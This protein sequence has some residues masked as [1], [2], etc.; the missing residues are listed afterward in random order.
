MKKFL[1]AFTLL[2]SPIIL[3]CFAQNVSA[4]M[5]VPQ[6]VKTVVLAKDQVINSDY[7][8]TGA[9]VDI[10]GKVNGDA[11]VAGGSVTVSGTINGDL[12]VAGGNINIIGNVTGNARIIGGNIIVT[13]TIGRN[14]STAGGSLNLTGG[15]RVGGSITGAGANLL[16]YGPVTKDVR[17]AGGQVTLG[18]MIG[19]NAFVAARQIYLSS[20][21]NIAGNLTYWSNKQAQMTS[22]ATISG[23]ISQNVLPK[24]S[25][26]P[27]VQPMKFAPM[28]AGFAFFGKLTGFL[29]SFVVGLLLISFFPAYIRK[30]VVSTEKSFW[31]NVGF[32]LIASIAT[33]I[34]IVLLFVTLIGIQLAILTGMFF[35]LVLCVAGIIASLVIGKW[36]IGYVSKKERLIW[37]LFTGLVIYKIVAAIPVVGWLFAII[38]TAAGLGA[39]IMERKIAHTQLKAK[40]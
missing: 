24:S 31:M 12:L 7:V 18:N 16:L 15:A 27:R 30:V 29:A 20:S 23:K 28:L 21:S 40:N 19:G 34:V 8:V 5:N 17:F 39:I 35:S 26:S 3:F 37:S 10:D 11:Y 9:T 13:G 6:N 14:L 25:V 4:A 1:V 2:L 22:G 38:F 33:P 36:A 32:G